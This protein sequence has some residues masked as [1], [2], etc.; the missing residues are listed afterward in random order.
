MPPQR[1]LIYVSVTA[2]LLSFIEFNALKVH[3]QLR[4]AAIPERLAM[5]VAPTTAERSIYSRLV[6]T[7]L[8]Q[9]DAIIVDEERWSVLYDSLAITG[10]PRHCRTSSELREAKSRKMRKIVYVGRCHLSCDVRVTA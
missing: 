10:S 8:Q 2:V 6:G 3:F 4:D 5:D 1:T 9:D 7:S